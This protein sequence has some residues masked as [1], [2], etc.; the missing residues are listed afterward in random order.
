M[1]TGDGQRSKYKGRDGA[2]IVSKGHSLSAVADIACL[3]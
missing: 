3:L 1:V 2:S